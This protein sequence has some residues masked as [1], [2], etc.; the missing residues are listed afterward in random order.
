M[1]RARSQPRHRKAVSAAASGSAKN[2]GETGRREQ[3]EDAWNNCG[4][5]QHFAELVLRCGGRAQPSESGDSI[6]GFDAEQI[7]ATRRRL[8]IKILEENSR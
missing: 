5:A 4:R 2:C 8:R 7:A 6:R 1:R 3:R